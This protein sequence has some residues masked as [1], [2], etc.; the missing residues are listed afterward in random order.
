MSIF[1][2]EVQCVL[3]YDIIENVILP[4]VPRLLGCFPVSDV[5]FFIAMIQ[6]FCLTLVPF[7][8]RHIILVD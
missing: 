3:S 2:N 7:T 8:L 1:V 5:G 4:S 6:F